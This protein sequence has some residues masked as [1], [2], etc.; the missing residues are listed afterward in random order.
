MLD[1]KENRE[2][3]YLNKKIKESNEMNKLIFSVLIVI[4]LTGCNGFP[5]DT[6]SQPEGKVIMNGEQYSMIQSNYQWKEDNV[7]IST[8]SSTDINE[9]AELFETIEV[10]KDGT[11]KFEIDKNPT[12]I[13]VAKQNEDGTT[14]IVEMKDNEI[15][16]PSESGY[17]IYQLITV[18]S[19]GKQ[20]LVFDVN[21]E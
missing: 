13:T 16:M 9:L 18:W 8:K 12:S 5:T 6:L 21:V 17:Y 3:I 20:T 7:E 14:D 1:L 2:I 4:I 10:E 19:K 11:L 15:T